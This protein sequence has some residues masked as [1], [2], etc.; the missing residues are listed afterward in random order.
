MAATLGSTLLGFLR[1]VINAKYYGTQWQMD[2]FLAAATVPTILFGLFNGA[3]VTALVPVFS[4]YLAREDEAE[5]WRLANT[6]VNMLGILLVLLATVGWLAAPYYVPIIAHGFAPAQMK[7]TIDMTRM[8]MPTIV[9]VSLSGVISAMLNAYHRFRAAAMI[10]IALNV[11]TIICVVGLNRSLGIYALVVGTLV[12]LFAQLIVQLPAFL[13]LRRF[14]F[15]ID[16]HH[17][18]LQ[19]LWMVLGPIIVGSAAGQIAL[20]FDR[21]FASTLPPGYIAGMNYV[22]KLVNFPQQVF[23][24]AIAT[25]IFPLLASQFAAENRIGVRRSVVL[26]LRLVNFIAIPAVCALIAL[27]TPMVSALFQRGN[28]GPAATLLTSSL[29][30]YSAI[31]LIALGANVVLT[32]CCFACKET[33]WTVTISVFAVLINV[34]L[35]LIW[36]PSLGARGLLLANSVSQSIQAILLFW[37]AWRLVGGLQLRKLANSSMRIIGAS[38]VMMMALHWIGALGVHTDL[39]FASRAWYLVGQVA[40]GGMVFLGAAFLFR[41][42]ELQ[43]AARFILEKFERNVLAPPENRSAPIA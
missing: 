16:I 36:L 17:P 32:R 26:G 22:T 8:L 4:E 28:F 31:G 42:E 40:I 7:L 15:E 10:G 20:F 9:A 27:S 34:V 33:S 24:A 2:T 37:L 18:G 19:R 35:S 1:E 3:L 39:S 14:R 41:V 25:V 12:G 6:I 38:V 30:P 43:L 5:A 29:L 23:A 21:F 13:S 11:A